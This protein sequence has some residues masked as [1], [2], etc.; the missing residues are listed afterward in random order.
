[1]NSTGKK[2]RKTSMGSMRA[3]CTATSYLESMKWIPVALGLAALSAVGCTTT[4]VRSTQLAHASAS[5]GATYRAGAVVM[6]LTWSSLFVGGAN[7]N[8]WVAAGAESI[9]ALKQARLRLGMT[10]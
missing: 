6:G 5:L 3:R 1:M 7:R 2:K 10:F 4:T 9:E 8:A